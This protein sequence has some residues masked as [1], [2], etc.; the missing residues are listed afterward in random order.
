[1][2]FTSTALQRQATRKI[3]KLLFT[4]GALV[5]DDVLNDFKSWIHSWPFLIAFGY[6]LT[7][8]W[9]QI[10][11]IKQKREDETLYYFFGR[12]LLFLKAICV[13]SMSLLIYTTL[14]CAFDELLLAAALIGIY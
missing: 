5:R 12:G 6:L 14:V 9:F 8:A 10:S 13:A 3:Y 4:S 2:I 7:L 1:M 11:L